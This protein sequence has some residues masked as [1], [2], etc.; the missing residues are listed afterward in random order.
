MIIAIF[1]CLFQVVTFFEWGPHKQQKLETN[2]EKL[3]TGT[4]KTKLKEL[5]RTRWVERHDAFEVFIDFLPAIVETLEEYSQITST[6]KPGMPSASDLLNAILKFDFLVTLVAVHKCLSY[7]KGLS[8]ALQDSGLEITK[9]MKHISVVKDSLNDC[10]SDIDNFHNSLHE[11]ASKLAE[12]F[13]VE[14]KVP[15]I[16]KRQTKRNNI[17]ISD[18]NSY[19]R[20]AITTKFVDHLL[21]EMNERFTDTHSQAAMS[22][23]L[24]PGLMAEMPCLSDF[25]FFKDDVESF[26]MLETEVHQWYRQWINQKEK[27]TTIVSTLAQCDEHFYPNIKTILRICGCFP[28]TSCE[29]ERSISIL[30]LL[31]T[32]LRSTMG[33]E[34]LS[35]LALMYIHRNFKVN[36]QDI[37][38][39]FARRKPRRLVLPDILT[40][41]TD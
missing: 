36:I 3:T 23:K 32:Y 1:V 30:R 18:P 14:V 37:C 6:R 27:P 29:C 9:A 2:I 22:V 4:K 20:I 33:Q 16:C 26:D 8:K 24:V 13:D 15:R 7:L 17:P 25:D 28:V 5:C 35:G 12:Q 19:Y 39:E 31:K 11:K 34:R 38:K 10:W 21:T 41:E 40:D